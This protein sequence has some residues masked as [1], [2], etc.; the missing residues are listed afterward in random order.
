MGCAFG[1]VGWGFWV[2]L[3]ALGFVA[4]VTQGFSTPT[5]KIA[6]RGPRFALGWDMAA[7]LALNK[8]SVGISQELV[9]VRIP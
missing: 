4:V 5:S 6:R 7:P 1:C 2:G 8:R 9:V 3:T